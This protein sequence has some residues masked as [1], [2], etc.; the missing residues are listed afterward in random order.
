MLRRRKLFAASGLDAVVAFLAVGK[1][2]DAA[3]S[4]SSVS[5]ATVVVV[6][7]VLHGVVL[8]PGRLRNDQPEPCSLVHFDD[9]LCLSVAAYCLLE[10]FK[11]NHRKYSPHSQ[12]FIHSSIEFTTG[13][14]T[15]GILV[16]AWIHV[17]SSYG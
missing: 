2:L 6:V 16:A 14:R 15:W 10:C 1:S 12:N 5:V 13:T 11:L 9:D 7:V 3:S 17:W 8:A 4:S